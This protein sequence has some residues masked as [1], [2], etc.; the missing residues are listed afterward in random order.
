MILIIVSKDPCAAVRLLP[1]LVS[2][3]ADGHFFDPFARLAR[4]FEAGFESPLFLGL[5]I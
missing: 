3:A 1:G 2:D 5:I 4:F